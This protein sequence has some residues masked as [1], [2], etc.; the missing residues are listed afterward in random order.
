[1]STTTDP[2]ADDDSTPD[3]TATDDATDTATETEDD[4]ATTE[5]PTDSS[6]TGTDDGD[7]D[8]DTGDGNGTDDATDE[9]APTTTETPM[10]T[11]TEPQF[12]SAEV[13]EQA[14]A[15]LTQAINGASTTDQL[16]LQQLV[17]QR[18]AL[19]G[20]VAPARVPVP[21]NI[22]EVG[23]Y[24]NLL[25]ENQQ[26]SMLNRVLAATLG[27][28]DEITAGFASAQLLPPPLFF[29][30]IELSRPAELGPVRDAI[31]TDIQVRSDFLESLRKALK[32]I[33]SQGA[34]IPLLAPSNGLPPAQGSAPPP[35]D[36]LPFIGRL[37]RLIPAA[38]LG[39]PTQDPLLLARPAA[40]TAGPFRPSVRVLVAPAAGAPVV[41]A[42]D[43]SALQRQSDGTITEVAV[44]APLIPLA[45]AFSAAG[46]IVQ[47]I[48]APGDA[49]DPA[50]WTRIE[51]H[52]G[53]LT[54]ETSLG[55]ELGLVHPSNR[56]TAS[57]LRTALADVWDG[58]AFVAG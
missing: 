5:D 24:M 37:L 19:T 6:D 11:A 32:E 50:L 15:A 39:D 16:A 12:L 41:A 35:G 56:I 46:W 20:A 10:S 48:G 2:P 33:Q 3:P 55:D 8:T 30:K 29:A 54:G 57:S 25:R 51:N 43:W 13:V 4:D 22:T 45:P 21:R 40:D 38:A 7:A 36:K 34:A 28:A 26:H 53:L 1:M 31:P 27:V 44:N 23:G 18:I 42:Q 58:S 9:P 49:A 52:S 47:E 17:A 14:L